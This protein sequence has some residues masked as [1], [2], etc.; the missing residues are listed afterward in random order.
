MRVG[1]T[2]DRVSVVYDTKNKWTSVVLN[3]AKRSRGILDSNYVLGGSSSLKRIYTD[4]VNKIELAGQVDFFDT[5]LSGNVYREQMCLVEDEFA[6]DAGKLCVKNQQFLG[7]NV[8]EGPFEVNGIV[9]LG[10]QQADDDYSI[11]HQM[12]DQNRIPGLKV[13]INFEDPF[14]PH[15]ESTISFGYYVEKA[16][17]G[18]EDDLNWY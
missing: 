7:V 15:L 13:G 10:P 11:V 4:A 18:S 1:E 12:F 5:K 6:S 17:K 2:Q 9:G 3:G 8:I 16:I 14:D